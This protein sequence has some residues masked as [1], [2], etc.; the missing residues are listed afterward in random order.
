[1]NNP[2][3]ELFFKNKYSILAAQRPHRSI[4]RIQADGMAV[5]MTVVLIKAF[6]SE[7]NLG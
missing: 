4:L 6:K 7:W 3:G 1:V 5:T 2:T